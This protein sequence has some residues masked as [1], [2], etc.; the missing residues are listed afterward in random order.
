MPQDP[1]A[2]FDRSRVKG[3]VARLVKLKDPAASTALEVVAGAKLYQVCTT[4]SHR[5]QK[6]HRDRLI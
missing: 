1:E 6:V 2:R 4:R 3:L 5:L